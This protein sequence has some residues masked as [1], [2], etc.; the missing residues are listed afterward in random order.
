MRT[1]SMVPVIVCKSHCSIICRERLGVVPEHGLSDIGTWAAASPASHPAV[2]CEIA[3]VAQSFD[4]IVAAGDL[5]VEVRAK[6][7]QLLAPELPA[8]GDREFT[9]AHGAE[10]VRLGRAAS[11]L[12][13]IL[14]VGPLANFAAE[15]LPDQGRCTLKR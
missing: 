13:A 4:S 11:K 12:T 14:K 6:Q 5:K 8:D 3:L 15:Q 10:H 9:I 2:A 7:V 1:V